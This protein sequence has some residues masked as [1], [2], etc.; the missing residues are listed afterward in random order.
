M[1]KFGGANTRSFGER[2]PKIFNKGDRKCCGLNGTETRNYRKK[3]YYR[4]NQRCTDLGQYWN[5][6]ATDAGYY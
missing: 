2:H 4:D 6:V 1:N 5:F 3:C